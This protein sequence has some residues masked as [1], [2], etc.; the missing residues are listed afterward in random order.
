[1]E[2]AFPIEALLRTQAA[3]LE[4]AKDR[5][6]GAPLA[7]ASAVRRSLRQVLLT[8][9]AE[10]FIN[11][12]VMPVLQARD[13]HD[14]ERRLARHSRRAVWEMVPATLALRNDDPVPSFEPV[15]QQILDHIEEVVLDDAMRGQVGVAAYSLM[16]VIEVTGSRTR[17]QIDAPVPPGAA[18]KPV[19]ANSVSPGAPRTWFAELRE[20]SRRAYRVVDLTRAM[21]EVGARATIG[22]VAVMIW[23]KNNAL[24]P[25]EIAEALARDALARADGF[26]AALAHFELAADE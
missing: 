20:R 8:A 2:A 9:V 5:P 3:V 14:L 6:A 24:A 26:T 1:M 22:I 19:A 21:L 12:H 15:A 13:L 18:R 4:D 7:S 25:T 23:S 10:R 11:A 16:R 17:R